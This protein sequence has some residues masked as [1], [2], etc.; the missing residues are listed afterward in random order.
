V[1]R[2]RSGI[3]FLQKTVIK[4]SPDD[5]P[6]AWER[7]SPICHVRADAPPFFVVHGRNDSLLRVEDA[8]YFVDALRAVSRQPVAYAELLGGQHQFDTFHSVRALAVVQGV[9]RFL[10]WARSTQHAQTPKVEP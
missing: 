8:R 3:E 6:A 9:A 2:D 7:A 5:D 1:Q 10:A 4:V